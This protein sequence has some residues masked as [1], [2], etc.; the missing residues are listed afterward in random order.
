MIF[1]LII[2]TSV[3]IASEIVGSGF[4]IG[5]ISSHAVVNGSSSPD[6]ESFSFGGFVEYKL[7]HKK[8]LWGYGKLSYLSNSADLSYSELFFKQ[9]SFHSQRQF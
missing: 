8:K 4:I 7:E 2:F 9:F 3:L 5:P 1:F 6:Y